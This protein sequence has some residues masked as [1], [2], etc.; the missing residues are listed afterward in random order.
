MPAPV[1]SRSRV[2]EAPASTIFDLLADP[3][4]HAHFDG[5]GTVRS[6]VGNPKRLALGAKFAMN[7]R[8]MVP[9]RITNTVVEF[10]EGRRIAWRHF[11][12]HIWRYELEPVD[13]GTRVT[14]TFDGSTSH[15]P[16]L[17]PL[18]GVEKKHPA[19]IEATLDRLAAA[20]TSAAAD[21]SPTS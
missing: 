4:A 21:G 3:A 13:G 5:S 6:A 7:M 11:G 1:I 9:Y 8:I 18:M 16:W 14:E 17:L 12:G 19:A 2:I 10:E 20:A 15:T